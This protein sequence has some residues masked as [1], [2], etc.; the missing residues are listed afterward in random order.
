[1]LFTFKFMPVLFKF[2]PTFI[3]IPMSLICAPIP[4]FVLV[5]IAV[6]FA[7]LTCCATG[8][9][10]GM[11]VVAGCDIGANGGAGI[12][13]KRDFFL[14]TVGVEFAVCIVGPMFCIPSV[15]TSIL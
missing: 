8:E 14:R 10:V 1:M 5:F 7:G 15:A 11:G 2:T 12:S 13:L 3:C 4:A 6:A 9:A